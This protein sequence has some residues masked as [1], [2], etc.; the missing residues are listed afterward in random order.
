MQIGKEQNKSC[1]LY[2]PH[3]TVQ[4]SYFH[5]SSTRDEPFRIVDVPGSEEFVSR[6]CRALP[7]A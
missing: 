1:S 7:V 2:D 4:F 5:E 6:A 3:Y